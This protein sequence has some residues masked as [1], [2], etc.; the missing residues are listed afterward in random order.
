MII[1]I[2]EKK[3]HKKVYLFGIKVF[4]YKI[5]RDIC[6]SKDNSIVVEKGLYP[7]IEINGKRN[8][9]TIKNQG[10]CRKLHIF[11]HGDNN[12]VLIDEGCSIECLSIHIGNHYPIYNSTIHI[13]KKIWFGGVRILLES[14]CSCVNIGDDC[15]FST[16]VLIRN[17]EY[18]HL[19]FEKKSGKYLESP[20]NLTIGKH[21]WCGESSTLLTHAKIANGCVVGTRA[22]VTKEFNQENSIIAGNPAKICKNDIFWAGSI[23]SLDEKSKYYA[24]LVNYKKKTEDINA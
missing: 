16:D 11:I 13:G 8:S 4:S 6:Y 5:K 7:N 14:D 20:V 12:E 22:V 1:K 24:S 21:V 2:K 15:V 9:V 3:G 17:G 19:L 18:P 23:C 10:M